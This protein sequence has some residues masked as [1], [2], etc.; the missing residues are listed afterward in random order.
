M[1]VFCPHLLWCLPGKTLAENLESVP[2]LKEGQQVIMP[3]DQPIKETGHI[4]VPKLLLDSMTHV[5]AMHM[6]PALHHVPLSLQKQHHYQQRV[7]ETYSAISVLL[8]SCS[9]K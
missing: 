6:L 3:I 8:L 2:D 4:Q 9:S 5:L 7:C 1:G